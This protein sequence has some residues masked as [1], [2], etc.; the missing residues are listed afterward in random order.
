MK[1]VII[2]VGNEILKGRTVNTNTAHIGSFLTHLGFDVIRN[3][4]VKDDPEEIGWAFETALSVSDLVI[5]SGGL[6]P[7]FDDITVS[8]FARHFNIDLVLNEEALSVLTSKYGLQNLPVTPE[9][10]KMAMLPVGALA[11][12][13][14][15]GSAPGV[16][17]ELHGKKVL[18]LPGVPAEMK[19]I[20]SNAAS[21]I[22]SGDSFYFEETIHLEGVMESSLAPFVSQLMKKYSGRVYIKTHPLGMENNNPRLDVEVS[23]I[24]SDRKKAEDD[25]HD[26]VES[27][28][29]NW[30]SRIGK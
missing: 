9:R 8:S 12:K 5:S 20:L 7:T 15:V 11:I 4:V 17:V 3:L 10:K 28:R 26:V 30:R 24:G 22:G 29:E 18:I 6:G 27:I 2:T 1:A 19:D 25:V 14:N 21:L 16:F 13:N 23:S